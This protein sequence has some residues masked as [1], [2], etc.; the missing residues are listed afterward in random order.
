MLM[1]GRKNQVKERISMI[2]GQRRK[3]RMITALVLAIPLHGMSILMCQNMPQSALIFQNL[4]PDGRA[5]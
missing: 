2:A 3:S 5:G 1:N 4:R